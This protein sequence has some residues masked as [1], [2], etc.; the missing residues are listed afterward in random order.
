ME[1]A[2]TTSPPADEAEA[3]A[4]L[5]HLSE[6]MKVIREQMQVDDAAIARLKAETAELRAETRAILAR[7][8]GPD[9]R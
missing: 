3:E 6:Q 2:V 1:P 8:Q 9:S 4:V 5:A 7:L